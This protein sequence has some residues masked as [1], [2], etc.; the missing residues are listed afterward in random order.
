MQLHWLSFSCLR[1]CCSI[2][3]LPFPH[4][5]AS[6]KQSFQIG[7]QLV[8]VCCVQALR[9]VGSGCATQSDVDW[10]W[11]EVQSQVIRDMAFE[12]NVR[13]DGRGLID[14]RPASFQVQAMPC[15]ALPYPALPC[16]ALPCPVLP[17]PALPCPAL[18]CPALLCPALSC[19]A[20]STWAVFS[21]L[22]FSGTALP[23][24]LMLSYCPVISR[25]CWSGR[26]KTNDCTFRKPL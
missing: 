24:C 16:P 26:P 1:T 20:L 3:S 4:Q 5:N 25:F 6:I 9:S 22:S 17:C 19:P 2:V 12:D 23:C 14:S 7:T 21:R 10:V 13:T 18:P 11:Q 15:P 8:M